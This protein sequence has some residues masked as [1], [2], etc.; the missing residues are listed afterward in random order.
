MSEILLEP[1]FDFGAGQ[2]W[3]SLGVGLF[4]LWGAG[5]GSGLGTTIVMKLALAASIPF[6]KAPLLGGLEAWLG[7]GW[8]GMGWGWPGWVGLLGGS[9]GTVGLGLKQGSLDSTTTHLVLS[10][11]AA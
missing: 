3:L 10:C 11:G 9:L 2:G 5:L 6:T 7:R 1:D 8:G 4:G